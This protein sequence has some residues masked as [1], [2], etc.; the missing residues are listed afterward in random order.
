VAGAGFTPRLLSKA[1]GRRGDALRLLDLCVVGFTIVMPALAT[2]TFRV[3]QRF[4]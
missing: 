3:Y 4:L 2:W 1:S